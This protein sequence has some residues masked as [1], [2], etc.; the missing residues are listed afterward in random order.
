MDPFAPRLLAALIVVGGLAAGITVLAFDGSDADESP[1]T[2]LPLSLSDQPEGTAD[3]DPLEP[4]GR[5][6]VQR[7][8]AEGRR[9]DARDRDH[10]A[11]PTRT[12]PEE[13]LEPEA[14][15][16]PAGDRSNEPEG[17]EPKPPA[18]PLD[19]PGV[20]SDPHSNSSD[21]STPTESGGV[22]PSSPPGG[23]AGP[24]STP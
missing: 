11:S 20:P 16:Q 5:D 24:A 23:S 17:G 8:D 2:S 21:A 3:A 7:R 14:A 10:G 9:S 22:P 1:T 6:R 12:A 4:P 13:A 19:S 18:G 15:D